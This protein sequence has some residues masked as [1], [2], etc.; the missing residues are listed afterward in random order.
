MNLKEYSIKE[1]PRRCG[2]HPANGRIAWLVYQAE[3]AGEPEFAQSNFK[4]IRERAKLALP[5]KPENEEEYEKALD[6][7]EICF[8]IDAQKRKEAD[9]KDAIISL[10]NKREY[11]EI[12]KSVIISVSESEWWNG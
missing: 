12:E 6:V 4:S 1:A 2:V 9:Y 5:Y 11:D 8:Y 3:L 7:F 10:E